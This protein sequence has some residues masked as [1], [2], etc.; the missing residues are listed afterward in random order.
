MT[1]KL[2]RFFKKLFWW[3]K[4]L[5]IIYPHIYMYIYKK[6]YDSETLQSSRTLRWKILNMTLI[7]IEELD[8]WRLTNKFNNYHECYHTIYIMY[9]LNKSEKLSAP[10]AVK[11]YPLLMIVILSFNA[12]TVALIYM[13]HAGALTRRYSVIHE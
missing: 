1:R 12:H 10:M 2:F 6:L 4:L 5:L 3:S 13:H 7:H 11:C 8:L 9:S